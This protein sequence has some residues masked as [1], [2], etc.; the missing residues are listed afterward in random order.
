MLLFL[1]ILRES[2]WSDLAFFSRWAVEMIQSLRTRATSVRNNARLRTVEFSFFLLSLSLSRQ[3]IGDTR[4]RVAFSFRL[5]S[6]RTRARAQD[7][8]RESH[9]RET[10]PES[11]FLRPF[12]SKT[13]THSPSR[14]CLWTH[15]LNKERKR[16]DR[17]GGRRREGKNPVAEEEKLR[18]QNFCEIKNKSYLLDT[19]IQLFW[20]KDPLINDL[21]INMNIRRVCL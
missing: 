1:Y 5:T 21:K 12:T 9:D 16:S 8:A 19:T 2:L 6:A 11:L 10:R 20:I 3:A 14:G 17:N 4:D 15:S 13:L 18:G 7:L